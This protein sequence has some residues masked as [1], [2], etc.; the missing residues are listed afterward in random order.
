MTQPW[1]TEDEWTEHYLAKM[2]GHSSRGPSGSG[3]YS[4]GM[5]TSREASNVRPG[6]GFVDGLMITAGSGL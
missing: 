5:G 1:M 4:R 3:T 6:L 2:P